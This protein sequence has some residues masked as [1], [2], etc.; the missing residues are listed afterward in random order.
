MTELTWTPERIQ[1]AEGPELV[2]WLA[3]MPGQMCEPGTVDTGPDGRPAYL[4]LPTLSQPCPCAEMMKYGYDGVNHWYLRGGCRRC[5][6]LQIHC[7]DTCDKCHGT[8]RVPLQGAE[9]AEALREVLEQH[10]PFWL[11]FN[12]LLHP[13]A[14][15]GLQVTPS[16]EVVSAPTYTLALLRAVGLLEL[17]QQEKV[18]R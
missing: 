7:G 17:A 12:R 4:A 6:S 3:T 1:E 11:G 16:P 2:A 13:Q 10:G 5:K 9:L 15:Y 8:N 18:T 14:P